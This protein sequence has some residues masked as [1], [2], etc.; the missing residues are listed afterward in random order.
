MKNEDSRVTIGVDIG[1]TFTDVVVSGG[2]GVPV[3]RKVLTTDKQEM[4]VFAGIRDGLHAFGGSAQDV[5]RVLH[6]TTLATNALIERKGGRTAL[7]TT[8]GFEDILRLGRERAYDTYDLRLDLPEPLVA[9]ELRLGVRERVSAEGTV[10]QAVSAEE[11]ERIYRSVAGTIDAVAVCFLH[12]YRN[13]VNERAIREFLRANA[14]FDVQYISISSEVAPE[15]REYERTSTTV[16]NAYLQPVV[17][18]YLHVLEEGLRA[19]GIAAPLLVML[20]DTHLVDTER[21]R[22]FPVRLIES[23]PAAGVIAAAHTARQNGLPNVLSFDMGG[24]TAK[25]GTI[26]D[27]TPSVATEFEAARTK[28]FT[29]WSGIPLKAP[30]VE[31]IEIGAGGGS[32]AAVDKLGLLRVGPESAGATPGP[33]CYG[34]G[35]TEPT[36]TDADL[37]LGLLG[38]DSFLGGEMH[39]DVAAARR[40]LDVLGQKL[41]LSDLDTAAGIFDVV[42]ET[43]AQ[44]G[45]LHAIERGL[46]PTRLAMVAFGGAGPVH[47]Y[48]V[49]RR[50]GVSQIVVPPS[51]GV[52]SATGLLVS[53]MGTDAART[54]VQALAEITD[55]EMVGIFKSLENSA[56]D[57]LSRMCDMSTVVTQ[58]LADARYEGQGYEVL[59]SVVER[60]LDHGEADSPRVSA[61]AVGSLFEEQYEL[62]YGRSLSL[63]IE[64]VTWRVIATNVE[65]TR[66]K[67]VSHATQRPRTCKSKPAPRTKRQ[68]YDSD[69]RGF[70]EA[71]VFR[72][73][74]LPEA[75]ALDGPVIVEQHDSTLV[76]GSRGLVHKNELGGLHVELS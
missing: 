33:A 55:D 29:K 64:I 56:L 32:I 74:S 18:R 50:L 66:K 67:D 45:R 14:G 2:K 24:T 5:E 8:D 59:V 63:P 52:L 43:M 28:R 44:A 39:V 49:A 68:C 10:I 26:I 40:A 11:G 38:S 25:L 19:T 47:A 73:E 6:A 54:D 48:A 65:E 16:A 70:I 57:E 27:F 42:N 9:D 4:G 13:G 20:S 60:A 17:A 61:A 31:L 30:V 53:P 35:G 72:A 23:G 58:W 34:G 36:V 62:L 69:A 21:A 37:A 15:V 75:I 71:P 1:G 46:D 22:A 41:G 7:L 76:V 51:A 3:T 12:A